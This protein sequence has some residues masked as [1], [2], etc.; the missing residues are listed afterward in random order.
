MTDASGGNAGSRP[1]DELDDDAPPP[2]ERPA[3][4][5]QRR[6]PVRKP[7]PPPWPLP[8][9]RV[10]WFA[11]FAAS[12]AAILIA[13]LSREAIAVELEET[14]LRVAPNYDATSIGS[15]VDVIYWSSI[16]ALGVVVTAE[17]VLLAV[18]LNRRGGARWLQVPV[19]V[20]HVVAALA[21][22]A[23]L[24]VVEFGLIVE[25]LILVGLVFAVLG[26]FFP[27]LPSA[28]RWFRTKHQSH[29]AT[30]D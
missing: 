7:V 8:T 4:S 24:A 23:F 21:G 27:L 3:L 18:L 15:L 9:A 25:I 6:P 13:F 5:D 10:L 2:P 11:S 12:A 28:H 1:S 17:A 20:L 29:A 14:L 16:A 19:L 30:P 26:W 22:I